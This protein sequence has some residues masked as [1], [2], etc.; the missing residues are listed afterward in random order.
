MATRASAPALTQLE[1]LSLEGCCVEGHS[2]ASG[3]SESEWIAAAQ[4]LPSLTA[5]RLVDWFAT[6]IVENLHHFAAS[7]RL[8]KIRHQY[9]E[10]RSAPPH[11]LV[12]PQLE[13]NP[14]LQLDFRFTS[15]G[16]G[17]ELTARLAALVEQFPVR[18][19]VDII[20]L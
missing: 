19:V 10:V 20:T 2:L 9:S 17:P 11:P 12:V 8:W 3:P 16:W 1:S 7:L 15:R 13:R 14:L 4:H 5:F 6:A 18:V